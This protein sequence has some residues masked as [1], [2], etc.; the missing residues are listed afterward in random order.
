MNVYVFSAKYVDFLIKRQ[1]GG[2]LE[3]FFI[4]F[5]F[6]VQNIIYIFAVKL[7]NTIY[8]GFT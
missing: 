7:I 8:N 4:I 2:A 6:V 1:A 5:F 3:I